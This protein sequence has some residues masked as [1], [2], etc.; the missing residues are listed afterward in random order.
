[1]RDFNRLDTGAFRGFY[2]AAETLNFTLAAQ[3]AGMTQSGVSQ[4]ISKLESQLGVLLFLRVGRKVVLTEAG[5]KFKHYIEQYLDQL[6][7]LAESLTTSQTSQKGRVNYAMPA[8]CLMTPHFSLLLRERQKRFSELELSVTLCPSDEVVEKL[9]DGEID[10][11]FVTKKI[12]HPDIQLLPFC[13]EEYVLIGNQSELLENISPESLKKLNFVAHPGVEVL[14]DDW[15]GHH[16]P[17]AKNLNWNSLRVVGEMNSLHGA[18]PMVEAGMGMTII[19]KHC[20][21]DLI[22]KKKLFAFRGTAKQ[23]LQATIY[24]ITLSNVGLPR[25]VQ[26]VIEVFRSLKS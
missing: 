6:E 10:F 15:I 7:L 1:M 17:R 22:A 26:T 12:E 23:P 18:I 13:T 8:S 11:G 4:N 3:R 25:R 24:I 20:V 9:L 19:P 16:F 21:E 14:F 5:K 2:F